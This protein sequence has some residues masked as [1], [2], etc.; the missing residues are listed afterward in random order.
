MARWIQMYAINIHPNVSYMDFWYDETLAKVTS[1]KFI[2]GS[3]DM[4]YYI[5][6]KL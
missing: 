6:Y 2:F 5:S 4:I 1:F 3:Y